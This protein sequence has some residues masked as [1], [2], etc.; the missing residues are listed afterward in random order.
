M[1][2]FYTAIEA[3][4]MYLLISEKLGAR[5]AMLLSS[6]RQSTY[7]DYRCVWRVTS[8]AR[9]LEEVDGDAIPLFSS[10]QTVALLL[11]LKKL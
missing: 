10:A 11:P 3:L 8:E 2:N 5:L 4:A 6:M 9:I 7:Q 1:E